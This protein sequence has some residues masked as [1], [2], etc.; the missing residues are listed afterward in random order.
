MNLKL[1][2]HISICLEKLQGNKIENGLKILVAMMSNNFVILWSARK[3]FMTTNKRER[4]DFEDFS[5]IDWKLLKHK[6]CLVF[7]L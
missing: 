3:Y 2:F 1:I 5:I 7:F 6:R 4:N